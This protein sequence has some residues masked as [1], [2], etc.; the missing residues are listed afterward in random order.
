MKPF[1][2]SIFAH[3]QLLAQSIILVGGHILL[4]TGATIYLSEY[5]NYI[6]GPSISSHFALAG[7]IV[8]IFLEAVIL[9]ANYLYQVGFAHIRK[10]ISTS[11]R[12][13]MIDLIST[14][15]SPSA[16]ERIEKSTL[17]SILV[18]DIKQLRNE[19]IGTQISCIRVILRLVAF[20]AIIFYY[21]LSLGFIS[22]LL[23]GLTL[24]WSVHSSMMLETYGLKEVQEREAYIV[25]YQDSLN[26]RND[27]HYVC[28][29]ELLRHR[30]SAANLSIEERI[31]ELKNKQLRVST[32]HSLIRIFTKGVLFG[33]ELYLVSFG[34]LSVGALVA[35]IPL[36]SLLEDEIGAA[37]EVVSRLSKSKRVR[38]RIN[39]LYSNLNLVTDTYEYPCPQRWTTCG[40]RNVSIQ[41]DE[42]YALNHFDIQIQKGKKYLIV[43]ENGSGKSTMLKALLGA[44]VGTGEILLD[45]V[46]FPLGSSVIASLADYMSQNFYLFNSTVENNIAFGDSK[47]M[48]ILHATDFYK[49]LFL[50]YI[51]DIAKVIE[52]NG[53][54]LSGGEKQL[55]GVARVLAGGKDL[56]VFDESF[57]AMDQDLF[58]QILAFL[59]KME[60]KT[61]I[62]VSHR[63]H[64]HQGFDVVCEI[65]KER[66]S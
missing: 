39:D 47:R 24:I 29:D 38:A 59:L 10:K 55:I 1:K 43:G 28:R 15:L 26:A 36:F 45:G 13:S 51:P 35:T 17:V 65:K 66:D 19:Y 23:I 8:Y 6:S 3:P 37:Q 57:S 60:E 9:L 16:Y 54:N 40:L 11:V 22:I 50:G 34:H 5:I 62:I 20:A 18:N 30:I 14:K 2:R 41:F 42:A 33:T 56:L 63:I 48:K 58:E 25:S 52:N 53:T 44:Q 4:V 31:Q 7:I 32:V 27:F 61:V 46:S 64:N 21:N 12:C 49:R